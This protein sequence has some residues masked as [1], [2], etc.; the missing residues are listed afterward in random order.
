VTTETKALEKI[1]VKA[2][3]FAVISAGLVYLSRTCLLVPRSHGFYRFFAWEFILVLVLF[4]VDAWFLSPFSMNQIISW[5]SLTAS[6]YLVLHG[7]YLLHG[8]GKPDRNR[9]D[10]TLLG[11]EKTTALVQSGLYKYIRHPIY[12][13]LLFLTWGVFFKDISWSAAA[14]AMLANA[15]LVATA[16]IEENE[17]I[18]FFGSVYQEYMKHTKMFIPF[19]F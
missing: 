13:S 1:M 18:R 16:K 11:M 2:I 5:I 3:I 17:N 9:D 15:F 12:G 6:A 19:L 4:N 10:K 8:F 7:V 14:P